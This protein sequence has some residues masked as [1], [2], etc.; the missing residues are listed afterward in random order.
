MTA[1]FGWMMFLLG[2]SCG[3][4]AGFIAGCEWE[5][6]LKTRTAKWRHR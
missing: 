4:Y 2:A 3:G 5:R 1:M 6:W